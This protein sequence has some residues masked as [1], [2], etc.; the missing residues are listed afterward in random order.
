MLKA[1]KNLLE[2][3]AIYIAIFI[4]VS[5]A[6]GSLVKPESI[7]IKSIP[8]SD[9]IQHL[10]AYFF[11]MLSLL[12]AFCKKPTFHKNVKY[13]IFGCLIFGIIIEVLQGVITSYRAASYLDIIANS[14]GVL[15]ALVT[16]HFFE[17]KIQVF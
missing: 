3:R 12:Y 4:T 7:L 11:L 1:I 16:F 14:I 17:K 6:I 10:T 15:L 5:I 9:K 8:V 13:L 2:D